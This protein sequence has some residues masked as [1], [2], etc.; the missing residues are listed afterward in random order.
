LKALISRKRDQFAEESEKRAVSVWQCPMIVW[1][2]QGCESTAALI[3]ASASFM[4]QLTPRFIQS[5]E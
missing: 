3:P 5:V 1:D 2:V 4:T